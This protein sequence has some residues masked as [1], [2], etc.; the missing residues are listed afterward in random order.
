M[1]Y[2]YIYTHTY[3]NEC[4][5]LESI[6]S[7][8][9]KSTS[10]RETPVKKQQKAISTREKLDVINWSGKV[11]ALLICYVLDLAKSTVHT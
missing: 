11:N 1:I 5:L 7:E 3:P 6:K 8:K 2:I 9:H 10:P 4:I